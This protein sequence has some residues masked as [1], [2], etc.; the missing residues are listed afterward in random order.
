MAPLNV[1]GRWRI[2]SIDGRPPAVTTEGERA[3]VISIDSYSLGGSVGCNSF[4]GLGLLADGRFAI[5]SWGGT[6]MG[7]HG[8]LGEQEQAIS[9]LFFAR[10]RALMVGP[11]RLRIVSD[12]HGLELERLG[13]NRE[14]RV[15]AGPVDLANTNWRVV[16]MDGQ[17]ASVDPLARTLRFGS[18]TWQGT[19]SCATL[20]GTWRRDGDRI[21]VGREIATT[22]QLCPPQLARIDAA[23]AD[24]MRSNPRHLVGPNGE[25][26]LAGGGHALA[27]GNRD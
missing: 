6:A 23:F 19:V 20:S 24:L 7:C 4:G 5:H 18:G 15:P 16:M 2:L 12:A 9:L 26:L 25:F 1:E 13:P 27:G 21:I 17:E 11:R 22:E 8:L 10:P 14:P 3:P